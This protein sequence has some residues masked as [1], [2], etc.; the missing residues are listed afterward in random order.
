MRIPNAV[1]LAYR[2]T[3]CYERSNNSPDAS[4][5]DTVTAANR[6]VLQAH[7]EGLDLSDV[8]EIDFEVSGRRISLVSRDEITSVG[9][10]DTDLQLKV[11]FSGRYSNV[12]PGT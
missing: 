8:D 12:E 2:A 6:L 3:R 7:T 11:P 5:T 1:A 10:E 9:V 4:H